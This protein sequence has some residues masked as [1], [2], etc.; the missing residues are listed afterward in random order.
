MA[1]ETEMRV[2]AKYL[3]VSVR[4]ENEKLLFFKK[5]R[6]YA[7]ITFDMFQNPF[8]AVVIPGLEDWT[9]QIKRLPLAFTLQITTLTKDEAFLNKLASILYRSSAKGAAS[10]HL[11]KAFKLQTI[12]KLSKR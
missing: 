6:Y 4:T 3:P 8:D 9:R 10:V 12:S 2:R 1:G 7:I 11:D 5:W